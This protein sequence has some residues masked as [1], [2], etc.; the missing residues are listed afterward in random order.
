MK[1]SDD[2]SSQP[3]GELIF[4]PKKNADGSIDV[5]YNAEIPDDMFSSLG[6]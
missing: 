5:R 3:A 2:G 6:L 4:L 1:F